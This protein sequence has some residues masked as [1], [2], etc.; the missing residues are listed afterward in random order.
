MTDASFP[1]W[2]DSALVVLI[3][4]AE[5]V[6][7]ELRLAHDPVAQDGVPAHVTVLFPFI[8][9]GRLTDA[10]HATIAA[11]F[12]RIPGFDYR[13]DEVRRFGDTV[14]WLAPQP[15]AAFDAL[16]RTATERWPEH[17]PYGGVIQNVIPHLTVGDRLEVGMAD[18]VEAAVRAELDRHGPR[19][20][21]CW[22]PTLT[23]SGRWR[24]STHWRSRESRQSG[25][26]GG[27]PVGAAA[28][29]RRAATARA[30]RFRAG[31]R[32]GG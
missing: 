12:A 10:L 8:P 24:G 1:T 14:V 6:V 22:R 7:S 29:R 5:P 19:R 11:V 28:G 13:F 2:G 18:R 23:T 3:P 20:S 32:A 9:A 30:R 17:P 31:A 16:L 15:V 25:A 4:E 21:P 27:R 26:A